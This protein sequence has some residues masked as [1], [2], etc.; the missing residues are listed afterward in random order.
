MS[1]VLLENVTN[2]D[3]Q[4]ILDKTR[5]NISLSTTDISASMQTTG[6]RTNYSITSQV[7]FIDSDIDES[8]KFYYTP[9][10]KEKLDYNVWLSRINKNFEELE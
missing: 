3:S 4:S 10:Y 7:I 9:I 2:P 5:V 6:I 8:A 1:I